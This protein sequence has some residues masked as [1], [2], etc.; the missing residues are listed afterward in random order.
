MD[1]FYGS[2]LSLFV[3]FVS[4]T[5]GFLFYKK[6][7]TENLEPPGKTGWPFLGETLEFLSTGWNGHPEKFVFD[8]MA[9]YSSN[10]F[11]TSLLGSEAAVFCGPAGNKFL[12][13]NEYKLVR[14]WVPD[15]I[16]KLFPSKS[17]AA[18]EAMKMRKSFPVFLKPEALQKYIGVMDDITGKHF[19]TSWENHEIVAV[20][21]LIKHFAFVIASRLFISVENPDHIAKFA[22]P[23]DR[24]VSGIF[25]IP[26]DFPGTQFNKAIKASKHIRKEL[27]DIIEQRKSDLGE[28]KASPKQDVLS[29]ML[30]TNG[31]GE[32]AMT[33]TDIAN[34]LIALLLGG[35]DTIASTCTSIVRYLAELPQIYEG[36][37]KEQMEV[38][39]SKGPD[40]VLNWEDLQK[41]KYSWSVAS[42]VLRLSPPFQG[43]FREALTDFTFNGFFIPK[44]WKIYWS[45][46][47]V[48]RNSEFF[49]DPLKFDPTRFEGGGPAPYTYV[50]F[51]GGARMCPGKEFA[52]LEIL[53]F[54]HHIVKRFRWQKI[55]PD[56]KIIVDPMPVPAKGLPVRLYPH[57]M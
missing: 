31:D 12:F 19:S 49:P 55:I 26:I 47:G 28:G 35:H 41:M 40:E 18:E 56:E 4:L 52:R 51:G 37:Y 50:P 36:V 17:S 27:I 7:P 29:H 10:V 30:L 24:L 1:W 57:K 32:E 48:H 54:M 6:N 13:S 21:P 23:F 8:R 42:E 3:S 15:S 25:S 16:K 14:M 20:Y 39:K 45:T 53:V 2:L 22:A 5:L 11:K 34:K 43:T 9:R 33:N 46:N 38:A 44:G